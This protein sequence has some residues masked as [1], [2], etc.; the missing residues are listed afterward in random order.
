MVRRN[1]NKNK[2]WACC[3]FF[4][5]TG[6]NQ[7]LGC[8]VDQSAKHDFDLFVGD[9]EQLTPM[10]CIVACQ[11]RNYSYAAVQQGSQCYCGQNYGKYGETSD[12]ECKYLCKTSEKCGGDDR[13][14]VYNVAESL[15]V[16]EAGSNFYD[17]VS[18]IYKK[19]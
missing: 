17:I 2:K 7:Y 10:Q 3:T 8:F 12:D 9:Y 5:I 15:A 14:S 6:L 16:S 13:N 19:K 1:E 18:F 11:K 4:C